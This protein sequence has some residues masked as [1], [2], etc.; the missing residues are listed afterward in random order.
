MR[1]FKVAVVGV[2]LCS[3]VAIAAK[4]PPSIDTDPVPDKR[5][6]ATMSVLH[7]PSHGVTINGVRRG[8]LGDV[9]LS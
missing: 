5:F 7:V 3:A 1:A 8:C 2:M 4:N 9:G 6:P